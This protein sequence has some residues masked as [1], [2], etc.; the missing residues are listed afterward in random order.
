M[1]EKQIVRV[2]VACAGATRADGAVFTA[3]ALR[4]RADGVTWFWDE[5]LQTLYYQGPTPV[6]R[7]DRDGDE[8]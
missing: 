8:Q 6:R 3:E 4:A 2:A 7:P 1:A 5:D